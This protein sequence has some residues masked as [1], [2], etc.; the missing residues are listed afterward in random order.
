MISKKTKY[1]LQ[2]LFFLSKRSPGTSVLI[3]DLAKE[4]GIPQ[5]FLEAILLD[6]KNHGLLRS[7]KGKGGGYALAK[8][9]DQI[10]VGEV[11]HILEGQIFNVSHG[12]SNEVKTIVKELNDAVSN[13]LDKTTLFDALSKTQLL[14]KTPDFV[15]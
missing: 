8:P 12:D 9:V 10:T 15:I 3:G 5:K 14:S 1:G 2:A 6:L 13:I 7:K 4:E 11:I